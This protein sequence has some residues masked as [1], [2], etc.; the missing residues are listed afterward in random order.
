MDL[1]YWIGPIV[2][3]VAW[4]FVAVV[5]SMAGYRHGRQRG[6][7]EGYGFAKKPAY[8]QFHDVGHSLG[9]VIDNGDYAAW[10]GL[11]GGNPDVV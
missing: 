3:S 2:L 7:V 8:Q 1:I 4:V 11:P 5:A 6:R 10:R 9:S